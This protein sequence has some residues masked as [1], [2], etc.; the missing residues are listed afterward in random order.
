MRLDASLDATKEPAK[1][2]F[3]S[4]G[5]Q[6]LH[7]TASDTQ[8]NKNPAEAGFLVSVAVSDRSGGLQCLDAS[9][10]AALVTGSLVLVDQAT[11]T[12]TVEDRLGRGE[13][14]LGA[15]GVVLAEGL[16]HLLD[17]GAEHR[18]LAA[19]T[20]VAHDGL[21]G[22]LLGGLDV[23]HGE[24]LRHLVQMDGTRT[25]QLRKITPT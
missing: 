1:A 22:A 12:E 21:L 14:G 2:G 9:V 25:M 16:Q 6:S 10:Q 18:T 24:F 4:Y 8:A 5:A 13:R 17:G 19:V 7:A 15:G 11:R 23:C 20:G 3:S